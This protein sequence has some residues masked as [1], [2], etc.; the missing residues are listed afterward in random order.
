M[1][2]ILIIEIEIIIIFVMAYL[3]FQFPNILVMECIIFALTMI[4][5]W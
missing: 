3:D 1:K 4:V 2:F 5:Y